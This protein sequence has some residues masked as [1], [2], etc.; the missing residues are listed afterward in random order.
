MSEHHTNSV[1]GQDQEPTNQRPLEQ[2][3][4]VDPVDP[5][6]Q[7]FEFDSDEGCTQAS[8]P[9]ISDLEVGDHLVD[10]FQCDFG[11]NTD[12]DVPSEDD[13]QIEGGA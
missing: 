2:L 3:Y 10:R 9:N 8:S 12:S 4:P 11:Y 13:E 6:T 7:P 5:V 1:V